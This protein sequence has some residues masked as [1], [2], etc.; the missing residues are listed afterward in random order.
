[1]NHWS[2]T[3]PTLIDYRAYDEITVKIDLISATSAVT[4][5]AKL[6]DLRHKTIDASVFYSA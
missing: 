4:V 2:L 5:S 3:F 6:P 1:M